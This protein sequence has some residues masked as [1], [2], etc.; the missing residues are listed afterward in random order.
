MGT[1]K[2]ELVLD[3]CR[4]QAIYCGNGGI[5]IKIEYFVKKENLFSP[6]CVCTCTETYWN[7]S[8][9]INSGKTTGKYE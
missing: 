2:W 8:V 7:W 4:E 5:L 9:D 1:F 6:V 3:M